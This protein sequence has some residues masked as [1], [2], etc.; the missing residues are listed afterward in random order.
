M[1]VVAVDE[2]EV[3]VVAIVITLVARSRIIGLFSVVVVGRRVAPGDCGGREVGVDASRTG[4]TLQGVLQ[5]QLR[6]VSEC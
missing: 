6:G 4:G 3:I 5:Q 2:R 1:I